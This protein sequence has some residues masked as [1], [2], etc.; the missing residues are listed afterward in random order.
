M[1]KLLILLILLC[2]PCAARAEIVKAPH[3]GVN[4]MAAEFLT[5]VDPALILCTNEQGAAP[6][7]QLQADSRELPLLYSGE[8]E[9]FLETDGTDWYVCQKEKTDRT[10]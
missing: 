3:H 1:R 8:G 6:E 7:L 10:R 9:I 4:A 5:A 2:L